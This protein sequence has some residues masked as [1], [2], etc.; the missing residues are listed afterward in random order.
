MTL[1]LD[2]GGSAIIEC[3]SPRKLKDWK[4]KITTVSVQLLL[5]WTHFAWLISRRDPPSCFRRRPFRPGKPTDRSWPASRE[6]H[7]KVITIAKIPKRK[8]PTL[9]SQEGRMKWP[10]PTRFKL[11]EV[12]C[13]IHCRFHV[14]DADE[15]RSGFI[16]LYDLY[17]VLKN[18]S[19]KDMTTDKF[20]HCLVVTISATVGWFL[21]KK[22][23]CWQELS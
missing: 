20:C 19:N 7:P 17:G 4:Q 16:W 18:W 13:N 22:Q 11:N 2:Y 23:L 8:F 14:L 21:I 12:E 1:A 10:P 6:K 3:H 15:I 5:N 9:R